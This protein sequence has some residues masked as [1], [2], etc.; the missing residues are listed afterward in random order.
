MSDFV[1]LQ[2]AA[3][4]LGVHYMTAYRYVRLG[5][6]AAHKEGGTWR[7]AT[8]DLDLFQQSNASEP[9]LPLSRKSA[10]WN[11]RLENRLLEGD[12]SGAWRVVEGALTAGMTPLDVYCDVFVPALDSIGRRWLGEEVSVAQEHLA[13]VIVGRMIG[14]LGPQFSRRG[15]RRG[16]V[17]VAAP[18]GEHHS[19]GLAMVADAL[20]VG[21]YSAIDLGGDVPVESLAEVLERTE[22]LKAVCIGVLDPATLE[23]C[24]QMV[25]EA[26]RHLH[27][28][29]PIILGGGAVDDQDHAHRL[30]ADR[31]SD[32]RHVI[33]AVEAGRHLQPAIW[34]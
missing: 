1:T 17:I 15:R 21:G 34:V 13:S 9:S 2:E 32:L 18:P 14:R 8:G 19:L 16:A 6:L 26:R 3:A 25:T 31:W 12:H 10:P 30:G 20:R 23:G 22:D 28:D 33:E 5:Q 27:R 4:R 11:E 29:V 24:R 7:V